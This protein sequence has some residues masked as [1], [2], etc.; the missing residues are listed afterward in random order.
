NSKVRLLP[1]AFRLLDPADL[2]E[3]LVSHPPVPGEVPPDVP[4]RVNRGAVN[5]DNRA[6]REAAEHRGRERR[7][8]SVVGA[9]IHE[10]VGPRVGR[11]RC[12]TRVL[13]AS[14]VQE[15]PAAR[16]AVQEHPAGR[17]ETPAR[18][19]AVLAVEDSRV[20]ADHTGRLGGNLEA[21]LTV[22]ADRPIL[23]TE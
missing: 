21:A 17:T 16:V 13:G 7:R 22:R 8:R 1:M 19:L 15:M 4:L 11:S 2:A 10:D 23:V 6:R 9:P 14:E 5:V 20:G 12:K 3:V 18:V